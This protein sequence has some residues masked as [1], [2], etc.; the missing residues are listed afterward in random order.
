MKKAISVFKK[1]KGFFLAF[2]LVALAFL[3][4]GLGT[5]GSTYSAGAAFELEE[6]KRAQTDD[7]NDKYKP[8]VIFRLPTSYPDSDATLYIVDVYVNV[9]IVYTDA[10]TP[11]KINLH[12]S[13]SSSSNVNNASWYGTSSYLF[14]GVLENLYTAEPELVDGK[15]SKDYIKPTVQDEFYRFTAPFSSDTDWTRRTATSSRYW[16]LSVSGGNALINEVVFIGELDTGKSGEEKERVVIPNV[17]VVYAAYGESE[18]GEEAR[19]RASALVDA[20]PRSVPSLEPTAYTRF[21]KTETATLMTISEMRQGNVYATNADPEAAIPV[22]VYHADRVYGAFGTDFI[23]LGAAI[24]GMSPFGVRFF[25]LLAAFGALVVLSRFAARL[26]KS[27]KAGFVFALLFATAGI[28]LSLAHVGTPLMIGVFFFACALDLV[29]RFYAKGMKK[30]SIVSALPLLAAG[31]FA[32]A[33]ICVNG[34]FIIPVAG[35]VLLFVF[36]MIRMKKSR[37]YQL[38]KIVEEPEPAALPQPAPVL[39][40][41]AEG[42]VPAEETR[43]R[44]AAKV[45]SGHRFKRVAAPLIFAVGLVVGALLFALVGMIPAYYAYLKLY[46]NPASPSLNVFALAWR[47]F[48]NG[49]T[50]ANAYAGDTTWNFFHILFRSEASFAEPAGTVSSVFGFCVNWIAILA[51]G[52]GIV[53]FVVRL[54]QLLTHN[55]DGKTV[56]IALRR[57]LIPLVGICLSLIAAACVKTGLPFILLAWLFAFLPAA[58]MFG[59]KREGN[60]K[61]VKI[62][63]IVGI[64][65]LV[66]VFGLLLAFYLG[67]PLPNSILKNLFG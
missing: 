6:V 32:A 46:D 58:G 51:A 8:A 30:A 16:G 15:P 35:V 34:A 29:H 7:S 14:D 19:V 61:A 49:F 54:I 36:G 22:D 2:F 31:L 24:F 25:P 67:I 21:T 40:S 5:L 1:F 59:E 37:D 27:E 13:T 20:Q 53:Y 45:I 10:G 41:A 33:A 26:F 18:T 52:A 3:A 64:A 38:Q 63:S 43:E 12:R 48:A 23:A 57:T 56:R 60:Q 47:T 17:E 39:E 11:L 65:L 55:A 28:T 50:G 4:V 42:D 9:A 62:L 44:R 66:A